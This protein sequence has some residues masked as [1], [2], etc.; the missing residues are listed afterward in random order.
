M[1]EPQ[2]LWV[3]WCMGTPASLLGHAEEIRASGDSKNGIIDR[4]GEHMGP[5]SIPK[6]YSREIVSTM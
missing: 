4:E 1:H 2:L 6:G 5:S 3:S